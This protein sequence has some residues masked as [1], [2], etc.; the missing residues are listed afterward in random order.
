MCAGGGKEPREA[1]E[2]SPAAATEFRHGDGGR[3]PL[4]NVVAVPLQQPLIRARQPVLGQVADHLEQRRTDVIVQVFGG[5]LLLT[6]C[7]QTSANVI[8]KFI[9]NVGGNGVDQHV[10]SSLSQSSQPIF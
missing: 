2:F 7:G 6:G 10:D 9:A 8:R 4:Y 3:E 5:K 1:D